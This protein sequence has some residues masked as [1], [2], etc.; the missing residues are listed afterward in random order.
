MI[1]GNFTKEKSLL[2]RI[3]AKRRIVRRVLAGRENEI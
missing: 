1:K 2:K 3:P